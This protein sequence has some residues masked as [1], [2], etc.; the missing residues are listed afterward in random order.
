MKIYV[1]NINK[2]EIEESL[3]TKYKCK[4]E[5][6]TLILSNLGLITSTENK[7][8]L[9]KIVDKPIEK[10]EVNGFNFLCDNSYF[11]KDRVVYQV[12]VPHVSETIIKTHYK[13]NDKS[14][15]TA[16]IEKNKDVVDIYFETRESMDVEYIKADILS[17]LTELKFC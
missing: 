9:N 2:Q 12:P 1:T 3:L 15:L 5:H 10:R 4:T 7:L 6:I 8:V 11:I 13:L 17:F 14:S 16:I